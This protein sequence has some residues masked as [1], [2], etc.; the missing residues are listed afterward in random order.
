[1]SLLIAPYNNAMRLGQGFNSYTQEICVDDAVIIDPGRPENPIT[2]DGTTM[3][4]L[5]AAMIGPSAYVALKTP[6]AVDETPI[7]AQYDEEEPKAIEPAPQPSVDDA[8]DEPEPDNGVAEAEGEAVDPEDPKE[9]VLTEAAPETDVETG[10]G[11]DVAGNDTPPANDGEAESPELAPDEAKVEE[12]KVA[13]DK[14]DKEDEVMRRPVR[15]KAEM[16]EQKRYNAAEQRARKAEANKRAKDAASLTP[17]TKAE[18]D[19]WLAKPELA[20]GKRAGQNLGIKTT[21]EYEYKPSGARGPSQIVTYSSRFVEKLSDI[22][23]DMNISGALSIRYGAI[24]GSGRGAFIN[25]DKFHESDPNFYI[26]VKV[27]NQTI[28]M[29]DALIYQP[30][31]SVDSSNFLEVFGDSFISGFVE[32]G[33][34]NA[35]VSMKVLNKEQMTKIKAEAKVALTVGAAEVSAEAAIDIAKAN[36]SNNTETTVQV[37]WSGGGFIKPIDEPW[38]IE[39]LMSAAARFPDLVAV[40]PQRTYAILTKYER[41]RSFVKLKPA[42]FTRMQYQNAQLYTNMLMD[43]YMDYKT[44]LK[45]LSSD[46]FDIENGIK[47]FHIDPNGNHQVANQ[48]TG[49][50]S[51]ALVKAKLKDSDNEEPFPMSLAGLDRARRAARFQMIRIV[52]EVDSITRDPSLAADEGREEPFQPPRAFKSRIPAMRA[53]EEEPSTPLR[54]DLIAPSKRM[55]YPPLCP[56]F[57]ELADAERLAV[58]N[59]TRDRPDVSRYFRLMCPVGSSKTGQAF[60]NI[61]FLKFSSCISA[62][63]VGVNTGLVVC[64]QIQYDNGLQCMHGTSHAQG[65][66]YFG[67]ENLGSEER[68]IAGSIETGELMAKGEPDQKPEPKKGDKLDTTPAAE[69]RITSIKLYTNR[70]QSIIAQAAIPKD[71]LPR[72]IAMRGPRKFRNLTSTDY[73]PVMENG[74]IKGFWGQSVNG[75]FGT[76]KDGIWRLGVIWGNDLKPEQPKPK[77]QVKTQNDKGKDVK[78][79]EAG[80]PNN[81]K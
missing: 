5:R 46:I 34:F 21:R 64:L 44:M 75:P 42:R 38:D 55:A 50:S 33:E 74:Y 39:S 2:N 4:D 56:A 25:T 7:T 73:D 36:I 81:Q 49:G 67:L 9:E 37:S 78:P 6:A 48:S 26:S 30:L 76:E 8:V 24:G 47:V 60:N 61:D 54:E 32:G 29:K 10:A 3:T 68:I 23:D 18:R 63:R 1:M 28:N 58:T 11:S 22:T 62:V 17:Y 13:K 41:L 77:E 16:Q 71:E 40:T 72:K 35:L 70:G 45:K 79:R 19:A 43:T 15:E 20:K 51:S 57:D 27:I 52:N 59:I 31:R 69:P 80:K 66:E 14:K 65:T 53:L 12:G